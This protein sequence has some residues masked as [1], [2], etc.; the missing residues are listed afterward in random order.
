MIAAPSITAAPNADNAST[1]IVLG[2][3]PVGATQ[4]LVYKRSATGFDALVHTFAGPGTYQDNNGGSGYARYTLLQYQAVAD[5]GPAPTDWSYPSRIAEAQVGTTNKTT[6]AA[7]IEASK[8]LFNNDPVLQALGFVARDKFVDPKHLTHM[9]FVLPGE[10][11]PDNRYANKRVET[12]LDLELQVMTTG[13]HGRTAW[14]QNDVAVERV[15]WLLHWNY[16]WSCRAYNTTITSVQRN[17]EG[18]G[19]QPENPVT[20][21]LYTVFHQY[22]KFAP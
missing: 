16:Q 5:D 2:A 22:A 17:A 18:D 14:D 15:L 20:R 13:G 4:V 6:M 3:L 10:E 21:I 8:D 12:E 1:D 19:D 7:M 9:I 11:R